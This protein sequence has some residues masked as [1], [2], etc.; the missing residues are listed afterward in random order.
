MAKL[1]PWEVWHSDLIIT[2]EHVLTEPTCPTA[3]ISFE[4]LNDDKMKRICSG[5]GNSIEEA[6][7]NAVERQ[8]L[9]YQNLLLTNSKNQNNCLLLV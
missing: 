8:R 6:I 4:L 5:I 2:I 3:T 9:F 7:Q 1:A